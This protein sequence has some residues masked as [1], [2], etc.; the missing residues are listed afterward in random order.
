MFEHATC[1]VHMSSHPLCVAP[2][3][4]HTRLHELADGL[5]CDAARLREAFFCHWARVIGG[6]QRQA[7][8]DYKARLADPT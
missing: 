2:A 3:L 5:P 4:A 7:T 8:R 1:R 6:A